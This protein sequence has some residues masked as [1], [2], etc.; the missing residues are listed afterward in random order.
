MTCL[1]EIAQVI[2]DNSRTCAGSQ[3]KS[4]TSSGF[5]LRMG[6]NDFTYRGLKSN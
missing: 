1:I 5:I 4:F 2:F 6:N 3:V